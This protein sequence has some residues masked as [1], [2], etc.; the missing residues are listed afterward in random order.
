MS[1]LIVGGDHLGSI[2][3]ELGKLGATKIEHITGRN[4]K[5]IRNSMPEAPDLIILLYDY[6]NHNLTNKVKEEAKSRNI[7]IIFARRSWS[8]IYQELN[9]LR[10]L[11]N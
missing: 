4:N 11:K 2:P 9:Y 10:D 5:G 6:V 1:V 7:P 8:S 3:R